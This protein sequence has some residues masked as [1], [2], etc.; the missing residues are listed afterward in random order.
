M[1]QAP[2][3]GLKILAERLPRLLRR[4]DVAPTSIF[5]L[6]D[7]K[8]AGVSQKPLVKGLEQAGLPFQILPWSASEGRKS[9]TELEKIGRRL[10][11]LGADRNSLMIGV[12]GGITTDMAGFV[13]AVYM[14]GMRWA[15]IPTTLLGMAD[16][17][18]G[19][20]TAVN[21]AEGKNLLGAFHQPEFVLADVA[22]LCT[23]PP[24]E[25]GCGLGEVVKS[26]M[27]ASPALLRTLEQCPKAALRRA[28]PHSLKLASGAARVKCKIVQQDPFEGGVRKLLNLG[29]TFGHALE[30]AAGPRRLAHGEAVALGLRCAMHMAVAES[31]ASTTYAQRISQVL[32]RCGLPATY[33]GKLPSRTELSR[34]IGRDKKKSGRTVEVILP[35]RPGHCQI[36]VGR[37]PVDLAA[38]IHQALA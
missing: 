22:L 10:V 8:A 20:K 32:D 2:L 34:L 19:G 38:M 27:I 13:A 37:R 14:R 30:T 12:G 5:V 3:F 28:S 33:P 4:L 35:V 25:W 26:A 15:A 6:L 16:A 21:L 9:V 36:E 11:R 31:L 29:H 17:A 24:R 1:M 7:R 18:I 23:L